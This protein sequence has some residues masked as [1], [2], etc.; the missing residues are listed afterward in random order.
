MEINQF[1]SA[2]FPR[3]KS[4]TK[5]NPPPEL[6][7]RAAQVQQELLKLEEGSASRCKT[8]RSD[9]LWRVLGSYLT[10]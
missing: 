10:E 5:I 9:N 7:A 8:I 2:N 1:I 3:A 4:W 6:V